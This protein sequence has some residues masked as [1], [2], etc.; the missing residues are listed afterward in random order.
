MKG[1]V[2]DTEFV[3]AI[4]RE[5][6][7]NELA[8]RDSAAHHRIAKTDG[9]PDAGGLHGAIECGVSLVVAPDFENVTSSFPP[10]V[11]HVAEPAP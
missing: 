10:T 9:D 8:D 6:A 5:R 4:E 2:L 1:A 3:L 11:W 7:P